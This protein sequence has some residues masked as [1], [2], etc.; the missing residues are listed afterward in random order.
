MTERA[1]KIWE[2]EK[3]NIT[4]PCPLCGKTDF[5]IGY[6]VIPC[7]LFDRYFIECR[8]CNACGPTTI[9]VKKAIRAWNRG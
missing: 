3:K 1:I 4:R 7:S 2:R 6:I 8:N 5:A 9:G